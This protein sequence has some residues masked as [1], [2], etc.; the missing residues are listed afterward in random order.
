MNGAF[1]IVQPWRYR[2]HRWGS[3]VACAASA[4]MW[5]SGDPPDPLLCDYYTVLNRV[6]TESMSTTVQAYPGTMCF[7]TSLSE[8]TASFH[9]LQNPWRLQ[10]SQPLE[11]FCTVSTKVQ[12]FQLLS[13]HQLIF[14]ILFC[15]FVFFSLN[16]R[17]KYPWT[18]KV[19]RDGIYC[20]P[21]YFL[22][23]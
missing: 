6:I 1:L 22:T 23:V 19:Q 10:F 3:E 13:K 20:F 21:T 18:P 15:C 5:A 9:C 14:F 12:E 11:D 7:K 16:P 4:S 8:T 17:A 2:C